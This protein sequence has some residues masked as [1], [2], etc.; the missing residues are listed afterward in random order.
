MSDT[1][2]I[3][4]TEES[5]LPAIQPDGQPGAP[6][7]AAN[8]AEQQEGDGFEI[9]LND[10]EKPKQDHDTNAKFA[11][12]RIARKRQREIEQS[13]E[14]VRRGEVPENLRVNPELPKQP[15]ANDFLS[16][17]ALEQYGYD[18]NRAMAAFNAAQS[19]WMMKAQDA[20]SNAIAE[21]GRKTQEFIRRSEEAEHATR[22]HYDAAEK[23]GLRDFNEKEDVALSLMPQG[24]AE[25]IMSIFPD[26]SAPLFYH[27]GANPE[28]LRA[29]VAKG[30]QMALVELTKLSMQ[31]AVKPRGKQIS[32]APPADEAVRGDASAAGR[33]G[34]EKQMEAAAL[35]GDTNEY[36]RI[37]KLLS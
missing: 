7:N 1:T 5:T 23:L 6:E 12:R 30:P 29:I 13:V 18:T 25:E 15:D 36:R 31:L 20:R 28:K 3:Q 19:D 4:A 35:R 14:A 10:D 17:S 33:A 11:A 37:K 16:D 32:S 2:E 34:L 24:W 8:E 26:K 21:Q 27:L 9:V 22:A